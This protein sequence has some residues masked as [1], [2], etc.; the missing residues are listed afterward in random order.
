MN[1]L[2]F[3]ELKGGKQQMEQEHIKKYES[4]LTQILLTLELIRSFKVHWKTKEIVL[5]CDNRNDMLH[6]TSLLERNVLCD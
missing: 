3:H 6:I 5:R 2:L 1:V 4:D